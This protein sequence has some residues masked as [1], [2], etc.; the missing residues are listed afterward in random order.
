MRDPADAEALLSL[1]ARRRGEEAAH[2]LLR[3]AA[4]LESLVLGDSQVLSQVR[5]AYRNADRSGALGPVLHRLFD[6]AL[7][8]AKRVQHETT[9]VGGRQSVG[10]EAASVAARR[11]APLARRRCVVAGCGKTGER[12]ARQLVKLGAV[13]V[14]LINRT[15]ARAADLAAQ[16]WGRAA[17]MESLH[18]EAALADVVVVATGADRPTLHHD[19]LAFCR[20]QT[21]TADQPLLILDLAV[22]RNVDPAIGTL[23]GVSLIDLD[24]LHPPVASAEAVRRAAVPRAEAI[25]TEE[26]AAFMLWLSTAPARDALKPLRLVLQDLC[27]REVA[28]AAGQS[29]EIQSAADR[30]A[31]RIVSKLLARPMIAMRHASQRG[32]SVDDLAAAMRRLFGGTPLDGDSNLVSEVEGR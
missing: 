17:P 24:A 5:T 27:R 25:A 28:Y 18:R 10:A 9:L 23:P 1:A 3:V 21:R 32:E 12:A 16:I 29:P 8:A 2:H 22:P 31:D 20:E 11:L 26:T 30:A 14:V 7:H 13:D 6:Q 15:P 19:S 4:G